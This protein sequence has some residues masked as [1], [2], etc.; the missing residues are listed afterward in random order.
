MPCFFFPPNDLYWNIFCDIRL[1]LHSG[2]QKEYILARN[3]FFSRFNYNTETKLIVTQ[4]AADAQYPSVSMMK[5][6][7]PQDGVIPSPLKKV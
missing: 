4:F 5:K 3:V 7:V 6:R 1:A 2:T